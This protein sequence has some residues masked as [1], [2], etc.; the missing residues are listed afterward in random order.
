MNGNWILSEES[1]NYN[2]H[3]INTAGIRLENFDKMPVMLWNHNADH[4]IGKWTNIQKVQ[5][6]ILGN[7]L[8]GT[9]E[10]DD[11]EL[12]SSVAKK[13]DKGFVKGCSVGVIPDMDTLM[14]DDNGKVIIIGCDLLEVSI[15]AIPANQNC[16]KLYH[17]GS[18]ITDH[19]LMTFAVKNKKINMSKLEKTENQD[20]DNTNDSTDVKNTEETM[21]K[22]SE[23][24]TEEATTKS[25]EE[26]TDESTSEESE[27]TDLEGPEMVI[28]NKIQ[29]LLKLEVKEGQ[30]IENVILLSIQSLQNK[31]KE[32]DEIVALQTKSKIETFVDDNI[33]TGKIKITKE[34]ALSLANADFDSFKSL[35][36]NFKTQVKLIDAITTESKL[37]E[38]SNW[39]ITDW[40]KKD[41]Q[42]LKEMSINNTL[43]YEKLYNDKY[44]K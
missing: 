41:P 5:D 4:V 44:K 14:L 43:L 20:V 21:P 3:Y 22:S 28:T 10:F 31:V 11:D 6:P 38:K 30:K 7:I 17:N 2:N 39:T 9:P 13:I 19:E 32:Y 8:V 33:K 29:N 26:Q 37:D 15:T 1:L 36:E 18:E 12:S 40:Q 16:I 24:Q 25:S 42:G 23:E 27:K 34:K 35:V